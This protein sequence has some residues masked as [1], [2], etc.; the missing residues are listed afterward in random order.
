MISI[1]FNLGKQELENYL[2]KKSKNGYQLVSITPFYMFMPLRM[3][4]YRFSKEYIFNRCYRVDT[5]RVDPDDFENYVQLY[6]DDGWRYFRNNYV[7][8]SYDH[9]FYSDHKQEIFSDEAS[10]KENKRDNAA[11]SLRRGI[12]LA[13]VF[14]CFSFLFPISTQG[15][16]SLIGFLLHNSYFIITLLIIIF[17]GVRYYKNK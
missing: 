13:L 2:N 15:S 1:K 4:I 12:F 17:S 9:I 11:Y 14:I 6:E 3:Y 16:H 10:A 7:H 8:D 5:R